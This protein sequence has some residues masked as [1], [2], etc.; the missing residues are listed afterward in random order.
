MGGPIVVG[1]TVVVVEV[2][3]ARTRIIVVVAATF[4]PR[5]TVIDKVGITKLSLQ[6]FFTPISSAC[7]AKKEAKQAQPSTKFYI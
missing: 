3:R 4:E 2:K 7:F 6:P 5:I 1:I